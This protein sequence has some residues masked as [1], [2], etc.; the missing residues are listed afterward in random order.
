M[1]KITSIDLDS[2]IAI[3]TFGSDTDSV[4]VTQINLES[5]QITFPVELDFDGIQIDIQKYGNIFYADG[6]VIFNNVPQMNEYEMSFRS[7]KTI[8]ENEILINS[9]MFRN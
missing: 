4:I 6:L 7:T 1:N 9:E 5:G 8:F 3:L 2:G